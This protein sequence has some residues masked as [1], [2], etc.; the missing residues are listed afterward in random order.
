[1]ALESSSISNL[2]KG[3]I[4]CWIPEIAPKTFVLK[5]EI[6]IFSQRG[7][8]R[9]PRQHGEDLVLMN[10]L[11]LTKW[12]TWKTLNHYSKHNGMPVE[13]SVKDLF[14]EPEGWGRLRSYE[15]MKLEFLSRWKM[16]RMAKNKTTI[17]NDY[18]LKA[19]ESL[20]VWMRAII[21]NLWRMSLTYW[22][23]LIKYD[24]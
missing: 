22:L 5:T 24:S 6:F 19:H 4:T 21:H 3:M 2:G 12:N 14:L 18:H 9:A 15:V 1:M 11:P 10:V 17:A 13:E 16:F 23:W 7:R 8:P 20:S